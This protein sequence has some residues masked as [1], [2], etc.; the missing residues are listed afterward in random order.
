MVP[1]V[2]SPSWC[3]PTAITAGATVVMLVFVHA[4]QGSIPVSQPDQVTLLACLGALR[5]TSPSRCVQASSAAGSLSSTVF[6][7]HL[8]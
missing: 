5:K 4:F 7:C 8:S 2:L 1:W 6:L 3:V